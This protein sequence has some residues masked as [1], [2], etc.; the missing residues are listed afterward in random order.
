MDSNKM[1]LIDKHTSRATFGPPSAPCS[2][3]SGVPTRPIPIP[4]HQHLERGGLEVCWALEWSLCG[5]SKKLRK[6]LFQAR[7]PQQRKA[8]SNTLIVAQT[9]S[10]FFPS[11]RHRRVHTGKGAY[12]GHGGARVTSVNFS[13]TPSADLRESGTG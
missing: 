13:A 4:Q 1:I 12:L 11:G 3:K 10:L 9:L 8:K 5:R 2:K 6:C 7:F